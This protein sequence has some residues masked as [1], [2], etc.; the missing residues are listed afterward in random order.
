MATPWS[1]SRT[2]LQNKLGR[3]RTSS[4]LERFEF[5]ERTR[6]V[7]VQQ[8]RERA[9]GEQ[10]AASL[11]GRTIIRFVA[12]IADA[13]DFRAASRARLP[14]AAVNR[15]FGTKRGD[16]LGK[17]AVGFSTQPISRFDQYRPRSVV[18]SSDF[19]VSQLLRHGYGRKLCAMQDLVGV[20]VSDTAENVWVGERALQRVIGRS[21]GR[22]K[23]VEARV[24]RF[25]TACHQRLETGLPLDHAQCGAALSARF[26]KP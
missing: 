21:Q 18:E 12:R 20:R 25:D 19:I 26:G 1:S 9:V 10:A 24:E 22:G 11:A 13:L 5:V 3:G 14:V 6:P 8:P 16:L 4:L 15:H 23:R 7:F 2:Q 17:F